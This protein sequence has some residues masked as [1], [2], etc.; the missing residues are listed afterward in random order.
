[1]TA[2]GLTWDHPRGRAALEEAARR[3]NAGRPAPL[4]RWDAQPLE[5]FESAPIADLAARYDLLVIDHPHVGEAVAE[6]CL[7]PLEEL[8]PAPQIAHWAQRSVGPSLASYVWDG[9]TWALPLDVAAQVTAWRPDRIDRPPGTLEEVCRAAARLPVAQSL[10]GPH[11]VLTLMSICAGMGHAPG[12]Q[13]FLPEGPA[14]AALEIMGRLW[15]RR[16]AGSESLNPIGL[17]EAMAAGDI[18]LVPLVFGYVPYAV[19]GPRRVCFGPPPGRAGA[20]GRGGVLGG[21]GIAFSRRAATARPA[22]DLLAHVGGLMREETQRTL[23][24]AFSGQPSARAAWMDREVNIRSGEFYANTL[25]S[26]QR[27]LIRPRFDGYIRFQ[28]VA[29]AKIR[30]ALE[31]RERPAATLAALRALWRSAR[32]R[33]RGTLEQ[34]PPTRS[35]DPMSRRSS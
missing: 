25:E 19:P 30:A 21:T 35:L 28:T 15:A 24:P 34:V 6:G 13:G 11:A 33:A 5:G 8:Y 26:T 1:M 16:A 12:G 29:S 20:T 27:A 31:A 23:F 7:V 32:A 22:P 9:R 14:E 18:A 17:L 4:I 3:A 10:A 2:L